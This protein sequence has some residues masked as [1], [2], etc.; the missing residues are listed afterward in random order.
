MLVNKNI[1]KFLEVSFI[2]MSNREPLLIGTL[3]VIVIALS[4][5][6]VSI[7][8]LPDYY[9]QIHIYR[10]TDEPAKLALLEQIE[11][12]DKNSTC[13]Q[14]L[15]FTEIIDSGG[16]PIENISFWIWVTQSFKEHLDVIQ[17]LTS[18]LGSTAPKKIRLTYNGT[19]VSA[20][21]NYSAYVP[22]IN[23]TFITS[24][25][26]DATYLVFLNNNNSNYVTYSNFLDESSK[27]FGYNTI[28]N[29][30]S[31]VYSSESTK[32]DFAIIQ[33]FDYLMSFG[34]LRD[35]KTSFTRMVF[36]DIYGRVLFFLSTEGNWQVPEF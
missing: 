32:P 29:A 34:L 20:K 10:N 11:K 26:I 21:D 24:G 7:Y 36:I 31:I 16:G 5:S 14:S 4:L 22:F 30:L 27:K 28:K 6:L 15:N 23:E 13:F 3:S 9:Y 33:H 17:D 12:L 8:L 35:Y 1:F 18:Q 25:N 19:I 2:R